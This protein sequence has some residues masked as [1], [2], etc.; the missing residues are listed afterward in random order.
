MRI[1]F[2]SRKQF[3]IHQKSIQRH[4]YHAA[5]DRNKPPACIRPDRERAKPVIL[6]FL[7]RLRV[8]VVTV[9]QRHNR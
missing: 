8:L 3:E 7:G 2:P 6:P 9:E 1:H 5:L 4:G